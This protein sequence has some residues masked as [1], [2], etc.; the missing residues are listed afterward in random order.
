M[1][2]TLFTHSLMLCALLVNVAVLA[3][4]PAWPGW[5]DYRT[6]FMSAE[7]R[8]ADPYWEDQRTVSEG[9]AYALFFALVGN[10]REAFERLLAWTEEHLAQGDLSQKLPAWHWG[11]SADGNWR[12]LDTNPASDADLWMAYTLGE[13]GKAW[14]ERRYTALS[15]LLARRILREETAILPGLG[16]TLLPGPVGFHPDIDSWRINPSYAP[17]QLMRRM[18]SLYPEYPWEDMVDSS[19]RMVTGTAPLGFSPDWAIWHE[20]YG[21]LPD[22]DTHAKGSYDSIRVYLW[23]GMLHPQDASAAELQQTFKPMARV[24]AENQLPPEKIDTRN[25][26]I[27]G[28]GPVGFSASVAPLLHVLGESGAEKIQLD[29][30]EHY[31]AADLTNAYYNSSLLLFHDGWRSRRYR[32]AADGSLMLGWGAPQ[33]I[34]AD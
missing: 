7:G 34:A 10:D 2:R 16:Q 13:A 28:N 25:G 15:T 22:A 30:I 14:N 4:C 19:I 27:E 21:F 17:V 12:V 5:Q 6:N 29:R 3:D 20:G 26:V 8:I 23:A 31:P 18:Q 24:T 33:C 9:Q 1:L 32:F 11:K